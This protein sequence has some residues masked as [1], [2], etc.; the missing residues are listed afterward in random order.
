MAQDQ[1]RL[2]VS[3]RVERGHGVTADFHDWVLQ[4]NLEHVNQVSLEETVERFVL[5]GERITEGL[6]CDSPQNI[7]LVR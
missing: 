5:V 2:V 4:H 6:N 3:C 7:R 1:F